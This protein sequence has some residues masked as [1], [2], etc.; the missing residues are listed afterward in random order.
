MTVNS[1]GMV[2]NSNSYFN[3]LLTEFDTANSVAEH[4]C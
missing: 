1:V 3:V 4:D 2:V